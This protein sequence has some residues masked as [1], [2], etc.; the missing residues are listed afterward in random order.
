MV[1]PHIYV[2]N[3]HNDLKDHDY[4]IVNETRPLSGFFITDAGFL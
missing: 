2:S 4:E 3:V 1:V